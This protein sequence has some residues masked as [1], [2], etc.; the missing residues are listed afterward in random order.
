MARKETRIK[1]ELTGSR[2]AHGISLTDLEGFIESFVRAL[3]DYER[4]RRNAPMGKSGHPERSAAAA[5]A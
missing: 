5:T 1:L 3:R 4:S 2:A